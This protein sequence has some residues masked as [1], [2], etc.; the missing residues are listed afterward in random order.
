[1]ARL[2][3]GGVEKGS[4]EEH[5]RRPRCASARVFPSP[6]GRG[7]PLTS[8]DHVLSARVEG[9]GAAARGGGRR[10]WGGSWRCVAATARLLSTRFPPP[11]LNVPQRRPQHAQIRSL[12]VVYVGDV[13]LQGL[14]A[15]LQMG[16]P[17]E[18][19]A[20]GSGQP[21][22]SGWGHAGE[23]EGRSKESLGEPRV[24]RNQG[25]DQS[26]TRTHTHLFFSNLLWTSLVPILQPRQTGG[27]GRRAWFR[28]PSCPG[29]APRP[30]CH[31]LFVPDFL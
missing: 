22:P 23:G 21:A 9:G 16:P 31:R 17:G 27:S 3:G 18:R 20:S 28:Q 8:A 6:P 24:G 7:A 10:E 29:P 15:F 4:S 30:Q 13:A 5:P 12:L 14:K 1:M 19:R 25:W 11:Y 2:G 26:H